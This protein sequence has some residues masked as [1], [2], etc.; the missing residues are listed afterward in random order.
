MFDYFALLV[1]YK[2]IKLK[3]TMNLF[4]MRLWTASHKLVE[5]GFTIKVSGY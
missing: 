3:D 5:S 4:F 2:R 1:Y